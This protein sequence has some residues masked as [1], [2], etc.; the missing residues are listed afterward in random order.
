M[1]LLPPAHSRRVATAHAQ[2]LEEKARC[3]YKNGATQVNR[4]WRLAAAR[5]AYHSLANENV[6]AAGARPAVPRSPDR[7]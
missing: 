7:G 3:L 5:D 4:H 2:K 6:L 1:E